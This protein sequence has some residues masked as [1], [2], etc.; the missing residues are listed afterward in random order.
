[1]PT[2]ITIV[3]DDVWY[4]PKDV[5]Y[6]VFVSREVTREENQTDLSCLLSDDQAIAAARCSPIISALHTRFFLRNNRKRSQAHPRLLSPLESSVGN[7]TRQLQHLR[8]SLFGQPRSC[9]ICPGQLG[10]ILSQGKASS[11]ERWPLPVCTFP[12]SD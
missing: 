2:P 11:G 4:H 1:M 3:L 5:W 9:L 6:E 7:S 10:F 8:L 12:E